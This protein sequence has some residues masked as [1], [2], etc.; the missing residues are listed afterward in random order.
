M[1]Y[2]ARKYKVELYDLMIEEKT[3]GYDVVNLDSMTG[4]LRRSLESC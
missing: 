3:A 1:I 2:Q 4:G